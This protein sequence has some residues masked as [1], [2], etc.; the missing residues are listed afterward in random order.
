MPSEPPE[1]KLVITLLLTSTLLTILG[2]AG[3][4]RGVEELSLGPIPEDVRELYKPDVE[5]TDV[6]IQL[7]EAQMSNPYRRPMAAANVVVST[8][9]L[10]GSFLLS[11]RRRL[12]QWWI[13]QAVLAKIIWIAAYTASLVHHLKV[14]FPPVPVGHPNGGLGEIVAGVVL[15]AVSMAGLAA[16]AVRVASRR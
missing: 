7:L 9:V 4:L 10:V 16:W 5:V 11:W 8:L 15:F 14:T 12:A 2:I 3:V 1:R 13:K 6:E